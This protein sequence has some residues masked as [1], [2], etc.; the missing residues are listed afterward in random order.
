MKATVG[1]KVTFHSINPH[2]LNHHNIK[3]TSANVRSEYSNRANSASGLISCSCEYHKKMFFQNSDS[4]DLL[5]HI[6]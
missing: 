4:E 6:Y 5:V 3:H 2:P 1:G